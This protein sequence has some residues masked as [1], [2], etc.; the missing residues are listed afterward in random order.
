MSRTIPHDPERFMALKRRFPKA[1]E[2]IHDVRTG[3]RAEHIFDFEDGFRLIVSRDATGEDPAEIIHF[4]VSF[5]PETPAYE[6]YRKQ[7]ESYVPKSPKQGAE[8]RKRMVDKLCGEGKGHFRKLSGYRG[9]ILL[10]S[11]VEEW[12]PHF[13]I[14]TKDWEEAGLALASS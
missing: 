11:L 6:R 1:I 8:F 12:V 13:N 5:N 14:N 9:D 3:A 2:K 4:S 10:V 7:F